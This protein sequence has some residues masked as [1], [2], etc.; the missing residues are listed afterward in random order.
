M[1]NPPITAMAPVVG[2]LAPTRAHPYSSS[3]VPGM[4]CRLPEL[5]C[6]AVMTRPANI[7][8]TRHRASL[9][10][11]VPERVSPRRDAGRAISASPRPAARAAASNQIRSQC[12]RSAALEDSPAASRP[13]IPMALPADPGTAIE[14]AASMVARM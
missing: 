12:A 14:E 4:A 6:T 7:E 5:Q 3:Q 9:R 10:M 8:G 11:G 2:T 13:T 1:N